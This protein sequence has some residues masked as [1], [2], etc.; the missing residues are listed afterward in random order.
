[1]EV[2][3]KA[4]NYVIEPCLKQ[5]IEDYKLRGKIRKYYKQWNLPSTETPT[6]KDRK[7]DIEIILQV[8][9]DTGSSLAPSFNVLKIKL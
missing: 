6:R 4:P 8:L 5:Y 7:D 1:M 3:L 2:L 9:L